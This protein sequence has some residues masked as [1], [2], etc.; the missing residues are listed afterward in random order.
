MFPS[1]AQNHEDITLWQA[2]QNIDPGFYVDVGAAHPESLS[3]TKIFYDTGRWHGINIEPQAEMYELLKAYRPRD[4]NLCICAGETSGPTIY[5][6]YDHGVG[7]VA[8]D[9]R[10]RDIFEHN[11]HHGHEALL[12][13]KTLNDILEEYPPPNGQI[14]FLKV[15]VEGSETTVFHG[16]DLTRYRPWMIVA[17]AILPTTYYRTDQPWTPYLLDNHYRFVYFDGQNC[18]FVA[19]ERIRSIRSTWALE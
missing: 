4:I 19:V 8:N 2:L 12:G 11:G 7:I 6:N 16:L 5:M 18:F 17:E 14:H 9:P 10:I 3:V 1:Y 13:Q 15:D